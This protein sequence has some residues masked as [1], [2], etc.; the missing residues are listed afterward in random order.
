MLSG[1]LGD[2]LGDGLESP[3]SPLLLNLTYSPIK[4]CLILD[5][6]CWWSKKVC[7]SE[8][9]SFLGLERI[10]FASF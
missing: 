2:S 6:I 5:D 4:I 8:A 1:V 3:Y 9:S 10:L 7:N